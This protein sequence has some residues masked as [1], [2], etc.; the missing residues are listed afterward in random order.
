MR[1]KQ[2]QITSFRKRNYKRRTTRKLSPS[3]I[4]VL[5]FLWTLKV[6]S[7]QVLKLVAYANK[8][9]WWVY[10]AIRQLIA[11]KYIV[12][13]PRGKYLNQEVLTLTELGFEVVLMDRDDIKEYRYKPHAP[14]HDYFATCLQLG[15]LWLSNCSKVFFTEQMLASLRSNNFPKGYANPEGHMPDGITQ[16]RNGLKAISVGYEVDLNLKENDRYIETIRYYEA[17]KDVPFTTVT[18][19]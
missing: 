16:L 3:D 11:E 6:A 5:D 13:L 15:D 14:A 18:S 17:L 4:Q 7:P 10:K 8:S 1:L 19:G 9:D 2:S 12:P